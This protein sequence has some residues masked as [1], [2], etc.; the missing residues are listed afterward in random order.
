MLRAH[1]KCTEI[2][3][4]SPLVLAIPEFWNISDESSLVSIKSYVHCLLSAL[5]YFNN[6]TGFD[7]DRIMDQS[8][9]IPYL[10]QTALKRSA[11]EKCAIKNEN[12]DQADVWALEGFKCLMEEIKKVQMDAFTKVATL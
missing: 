11:F 9:D 3:K 8:K 5:R 2:S 7:V 1:V 4:L 12:T 6:K 10:K